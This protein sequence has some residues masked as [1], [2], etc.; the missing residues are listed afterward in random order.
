MSFLGEGIKGHFYSFVY[1]S[2]FTKLFTMAI[3]SI[4]KS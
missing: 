2:V 4:Y 1:T 3:P